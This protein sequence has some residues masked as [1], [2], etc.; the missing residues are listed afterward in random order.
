MGKESSNPETG[1]DTRREEQ[2]GGKPLQFRN[3]EIEKFRK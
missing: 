1:E 3:F 2:G